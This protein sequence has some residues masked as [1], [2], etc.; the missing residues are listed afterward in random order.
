MNFDIAKNKVKHINKLS[1]D[2]KYEICKDGRI[3]SKVRNK[4]LK[5][6][7]NNNG[8]MYINDGNKNYLVHRLVA[9]KYIPNPNNY[10]QINHKDE[11]KT[12][13]NVDNLEWC[14]AKYN[15][16]YSFGKKVYC[17]DKTYNLYKVYESVS[18]LGD[19]GYNVSNVSRCANGNLYT[20]NELVFS[21]TELTFAEVR[22][23]YINYYKGF[24]GKSKVNINF[25]E[26]DI[27][28]I[29]IAYIKSLASGKEVYQYDTNYN[30]INK[31]RCPYE[32]SFYKDNKDAFL[33]A[34]RQKS[35]H[36]GYIWSYEPINPR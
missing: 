33:S 32:V 28:D 26:F 13:N 7:I 10:N 16:K 30:L 24:I 6:G 20:V 8:Y 3:Y 4:Y 14:D 9:E 31:Y 18:E 5:P 25:D 15:M 23:R 2:D 27:K 11:D 17:Y 29:N 34:C 19:L 12:N 36:K 1:F 21:Y 35:K 22:E